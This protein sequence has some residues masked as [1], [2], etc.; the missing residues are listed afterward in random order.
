[1]RPTVR[2]VPN[3]RCRIRRGQVPTM[4]ITQEQIRV[5]QAHQRGAAH[6]KSPQVR[7][8]AGPGTGKSQVI[9]ERVRWL[10]SKGVVPNEIFVVSFTNASARDLQQRLHQSR[11][12]HDDPGTGTISVSTLHSLALRIL[13]SAGKLSQYP[14]P[15]TVLGD[16]ETEHIID[17]EF[18]ARCE[19]TLGKTQTLRRSREIRKQY[20]AFWSTDQWRPPN[21]QPSKPPVTKEE[22]AAFNSFHELRT[23]CYACVLPGEIVRQCVTAAA[24]GLLD[25]TSPLSI[26]HLIVDEVQDLNP[27]DIEFVRRIAKGGA[28]VFIA[29]DDDQSIYSFRHAYPEGFQSFP[30]TFDSCGDHVLTHCFR[31]APAILSAADTL[32]S[33]YSLPSRIPKNLVSLLGAATPPVFGVSHLWKF[34]SEQAE[35]R[36]IASSC[37]D[38]IASGVPPSEILILAPEREP[39][40]GRIAERLRLSG[41]SVD[42]P[43]SD[44]FTDTETY[45]FLVS[46][47]RVVC[48]NEDYVAHRLLLGTRRDVDPKTCDAIAA[49]TTAL[50]LNYR[51]LYYGD[52]P[53]DA[54]GLLGTAIVETRKVCVEIG[55]WSRSDTVACR[56]ER[57]RTILAEGRGEGE[58]HHWDTL[59]ERIPGEMEMGDLREYL[60]IKKEDL[61]EEYLR[62]VCDRLGVSMSED[63]VQPSRVRL[64]T[65]HGAK[66]LQASV[67]F[68]PGLEEEILPG[69]KRS[70]Y[71]GLV[72]EA[73]RLLYV[74]ITR[75]RIAC[76]VS[77]AWHRTVWGKFGKRMPSRFA[78]NLGGVFE[79]RN[80][81]LSEVEVRAIQRERSLA[82]NG[83]E[84]EGRSEG[85]VATA[86][87]RNGDSVG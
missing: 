58:C 32:I 10:L 57:V 73:A 46:V 80:S 81:G 70:S 36:A 76:V 82:L 72:A 7:L 26:E 69:N 37:R 84:A 34:K 86:G 3:F 5:A 74:S 45:W 11:R 52:A 40:L 71:A 61:R 29:G 67:V 54:L 55:A 28:H 49:T 18:S 77:L 12:E 87:E 41:V 79:C 85:V 25:L 15:P 6:D 19:K 39:V 68:V 38:L 83:S 20:E 9:C 21:Y 50:N 51:A 16:W 53:P 62:R 65:M 4:P 33:D 60:T 43:E 17:A 63:G 75:A 22:R 78:K 42:E 48:D 24:K 23:Q 66:G 56:G 2:I 27:M 64:M 47:L 59:L 44:E 1:M 13:K 35:A 8:V 31:C 30:D 14:A